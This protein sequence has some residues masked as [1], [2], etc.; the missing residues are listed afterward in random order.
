MLWKCCTQHVSKSRKLSS[1]HRIEKGQF[2][3]QSQKEAMPKNAQTTIQL[4]S[5]ARKVMLKI[6][7]ARLQQNMNWEL[8]DVQTGFRKD[9]NERSNCQRMKSGEEGDYRRWDG[10]MASLTQWT[11]VWASSGRWCRTGKPGML[12]SLGSHRVGHNWET[13][14]QQQ[15]AQE[16]NCWV[17]W[18]IYF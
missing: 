3:S 17:I 2:S 1:G 16:W 15:N 4:Y 13:K 8:P 14:Q 18:C 11:W 7:Q 5:H 10:W 9:L 12:Q 6:L